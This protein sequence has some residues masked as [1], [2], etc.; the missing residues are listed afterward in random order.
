MYV[1]SMMY[2]WP[3]P[4]EVGLHLNLVFL[5][6]FCS[7]GEGGGGGAGVLRVFFVSAS[8]VD[9]HDR[10]LT[11]SLSSTNSSFRYGSSLTRSVGY[12]KCPW[13]LILP[14]E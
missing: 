13:L 7:I 8:A 4:L 14:R 5:G 11:C 3:V 9:N 6:H 1:L 10:I 12:D 2:R